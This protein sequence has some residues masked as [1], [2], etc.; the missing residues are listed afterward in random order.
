MRI[1]NILTVITLIIS[2]TFAHGQETVTQPVGLAAYTLKLDNFE[3]LTKSLKHFR[4]HYFSG[5]KA[6][7]EID[8]LIIQK[9]AMLESHF[10]IL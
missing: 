9:E 5:S 8:S 6:E 1:T 3:R 7:R 4:I 2:C 10:D